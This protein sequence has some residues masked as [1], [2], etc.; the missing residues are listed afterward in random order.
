[1]KNFYV[2]VIRPTLEYG[3]QVWKGGI[4]KDQSNEI[5]RIQI[6]NEHLKLSTRKMTMISVYKL[7]N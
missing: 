4:T 7:Q 5:E 1:M 6:K 3:A 2:A